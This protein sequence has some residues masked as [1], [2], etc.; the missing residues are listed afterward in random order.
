MS[1]TCHTGHPIRTDQHEQPVTPPQ[2]PCHACHTPPEGDRPLPERPSDTPTM[3]TVPE[4][5]A[6][7]RIS[8]WTLYNLIRSRQ[9][10]TVTI[11]RRRLIPRQALNNYINR[12]IQ[13]VA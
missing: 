1:H 6:E 8:R 7:L 4:A 13:E 10:D 5:M 11:G 12:L 9:L 3:L 2:V